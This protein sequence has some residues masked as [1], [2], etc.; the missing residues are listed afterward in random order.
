MLVSGRYV[1][2]SIV[3]HTGL[4]E[5]PAAG[6][7]QSATAHRPAV[8]LYFY[9][10]HGKRT[11]QE[12][13]GFLQDPLA[14]GGDLGLEGW[15]CRCARA[16]RRARRLRRLSRARSDDAVEGLLVLGLLLSGMG[17]LFHG[18]VNQEDWRERDCGG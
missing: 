2:P 1:R 12:V 15:P 10:T 13:F 9:A 3:A 11:R 4:C 8:L 6:V 18:V 5:G 16:I 14:F 7:Q 17:T